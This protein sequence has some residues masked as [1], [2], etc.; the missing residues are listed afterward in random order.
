M[1]LVRNFRCSL[2]TPSRLL[3]AA[4]TGHEEVVG[5]RLNHDVGG[6]R[7]G[8]VQGPQ[9]RW[10]CGVVVRLVDLEHTEDDIF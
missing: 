6:A 10:A 1:F 2:F 8:G 5:V 7:V 4:T 9:G 3:S